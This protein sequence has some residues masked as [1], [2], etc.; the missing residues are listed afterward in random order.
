MTLVLK[1]QN[2]N[3]CLLVLLNM[4]IS[5]HISPDYKNH[6]TYDHEI[7]SKIFQEE[8]IA[9]KKCSHKKRKQSKPF[10]VSQVI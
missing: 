5:N 2:I 7:N 10:N 1:C 8:T 9:L 6:S 4:T 3:F